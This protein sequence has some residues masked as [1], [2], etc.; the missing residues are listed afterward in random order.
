K[1]LID[2]TTQ[3]SK[4]TEAIAHRYRLAI[5]YFLSHDPRETWE[6]ADTLAIKEPLVIHHIQQMV[7]AGW[8]KR[9]R[10]GRR[11][12][13]TLKK[14]AAID[15]FKFLG[16]TPFFRNIFPKASKKS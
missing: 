14:E 5:L 3:L 8:V 15:L 16:Q 9:I 11:V 2:K 1:R 6:I 12:T 10:T 4:L 7:I 13:Y